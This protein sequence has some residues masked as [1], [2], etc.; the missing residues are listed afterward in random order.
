MPRKLGIFKQH[1]SEILQLLDQ[2]EGY[3]KIRHYLEREY[4]IKCTRQNLKKSHQRYLK[5]QTSNTHVKKAKKVT[6]KTAKRNPTK[7]PNRYPP[8]ALESI[9]SSPEEV[10]KT[11]DS[12]KR[13]QEILFNLETLLD[14]ECATERFEAYQKASLRSWANLL[15]SI[16]PETA[17]EVFENNYG[18][19]FTTYEDAVM[20]ALERI[21]KNGLYNEF[22][23]RELP[24]QEEVAMDFM[25][26]DQK[27]RI[28][29][30]RDE[31]LAHGDKVQ[32][33]HDQRIRRRKN[34]TE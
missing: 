23:T 28:R 24:A 9:W 29:K 2:G 16:H 10:A 22:S 14:A 21:K 7:R 17:M 27:T 31:I 8:E 25:I 20:D 4:G 13:D 34:Q 15:F 18:A 11:L 5:N 32:M 30:T 1:Q 6:D 3:E 26:L 33:L 19:N 12:R